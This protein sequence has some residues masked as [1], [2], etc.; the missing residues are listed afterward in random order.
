MGA[1]CFYHVDPGGQLRV[2]RLT[3]RPLLASPSCRPLRTTFK[4][5]QD[6]KK[7]KSLYE[8]GE[9]IHQQNRKSLPLKRTSFPQRVARAEPTL[10]Q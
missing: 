6:Y 2:P 10:L 5:S 4:K 8:W 1:A 3:V 7:K 9:K